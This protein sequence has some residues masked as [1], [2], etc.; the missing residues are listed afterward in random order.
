VGTKVKPWHDGVPNGSG[1][2]SLGTVAAR[3]V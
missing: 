2:R 3:V 1:W